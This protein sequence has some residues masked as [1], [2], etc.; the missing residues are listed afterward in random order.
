MDGLGLS[1][2]Q[3]EIIR[4]TL[5]E[6]FGA[7]SKIWLF[8]SRAQGDVRGDVDLYVESSSACSLT[9]KLATRRHLEESLHQ[10]VDLIVR[11]NGDP[12]TAIDDIAK[13]TGLAL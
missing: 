3:T 11:T 5:A 10:K 2:S 13:T 12:H 8:G 4:T 6:A 9:T 7:D 1:Q